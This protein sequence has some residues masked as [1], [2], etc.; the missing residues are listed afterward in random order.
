MR[1]RRHTLNKVGNQPVEI[2]CRTGKR[3]HRRSFLS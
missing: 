1:D 3:T 2:L